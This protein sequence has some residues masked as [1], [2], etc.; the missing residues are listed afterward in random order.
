[1]HADDIPPPVFIL[2]APGLPAPTL[3]AALGANPRAYGLPEINLPLMLTVDVYQREMTGPRGPQG[4]G[5]LRALAQI[6]GGEQTSAAIEMARR[7][8]DLRAWMPAGDVHREIAARI[9]PRVMVSPAT[10]VI[11]DPPSL[12]RMLAMFP[13]ARFVRLRAH[14][15]VYG[16][17]MLSG[18]TGQIALQLSGAIDE[19][20]DAPIPDPQEL[21]LTVETALDESLAELP[22]SRV[23]PV[24]T[25][26]L[27]ADPGP[28]LK[29]LARKLG[30]AY[31]AEAVAAM[32]R[33]ERAPFA[34]PGPMG[35]HING[36]IFS[37]AALAGE[38]PAPGTAVLDGALPWRPDGKGF[39]DSVAERARALGFA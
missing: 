18:P 16:E 25:E 39:R 29:G 17:V 8:L 35:A 23:I 34:G 21:W 13:D 3:A 9:A 14:P 20:G 22:E 36:H 38:F 19:E 10:A 12:R 4:H 27:V 5:L 24:L 31:G 2:A 30:L 1:M 11:L 15:R 32:T 28:V 33:P 7:W 26:E 6:L 37:F